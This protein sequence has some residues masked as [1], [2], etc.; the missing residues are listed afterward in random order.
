MSSTGFLRMAVAATI[1][2]SGTVAH[3]DNFTLRMGSGHTTGLTYVAVYDTFFEEEV[4]R[5]VEEETDHTVRFIKAWGG[6]VARVDGTIEAVQRGTLDIGLSPIGFEQTR[7]ALLNYSAAVPFTTSDPVLQQ[8]VANRMVAEVPALQESMDPYNSH[9]LGMMVTEAYGVATNFD[10]ENI[11]QLEGR[12]IAMAGTNAPLF[13]PLDAVPINLGVGE[14]YQA[15][16]T[17]MAEGSLFFI[18]GMENFQLK[19]VANTFVNT[20]FGSLSTLVAFMSQT[21]RT[22]LPDEVV[23][24]IDEVAAEATL[25]VAEQ[26]KEL[27][28]AVAQRLTEE[29]ITVRDLGDDERARWASLAGEIPANFVADLEDRDLPARDVLNAY[30]RMLE[31]EGY[32]LPAQ[33]DF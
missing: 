29:G 3:S 7:A 28:E 9:I 5:R 14:H 13:L 30:I 26:S 24:I 16:Q 31:E 18:S 23:A 12:R 8:T 32:Q 27:Q 4:T 22:R 17:G 10:W 21:T 2:L 20:G 33:Y 1:V 15:M 11:D 19:E 6:S 25:R